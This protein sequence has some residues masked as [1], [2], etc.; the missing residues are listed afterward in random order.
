MKPILRNLVLLIFCTTPWIAAAQTEDITRNL[1]LRMFNDYWNARNLEALNEF[2]DEDF[3]YT[4][5][6]PQ[7]NIESVNQAAV[8]RKRLSSSYP[9]LE[10]VLEDILVDGNKSFMRA[11]VSFEHTIWVPARP[12]GLASPTNDKVSY[13]IWW[14]YVVKDGKIVEGIELFDEKSRNVQMGIFPEE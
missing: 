7:G 1:S 14:V 13:Q 11:S 12:Y 5:S 2:V 3:R 9:E 10:Y 4:S 8:Y 6:D